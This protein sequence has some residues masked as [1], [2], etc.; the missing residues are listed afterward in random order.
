MNPGD[1]QAFILAI[2]F[3]VLLDVGILTGFVNLGF[4]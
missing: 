4:S 3:F 2:V 1:K